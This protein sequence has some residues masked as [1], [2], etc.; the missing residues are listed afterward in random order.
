M[1]LLRIFVIESSRPVLRRP[2]AINTSAP[3]VRNA[4]GDAIKDLQGAHISL[5]A[6]PGDVQRQPAHGTSIPIHGGPGDPNGEFNAIYATFDPG[7]GFEPIQ[8]GSSYVQAVTW[9]DS[10]CPDARTI[11]TY[12]LS[13]NPRSPFFDDQTAMF[14][15]KQWVHERFCAADVKQH[16]VSITHV[17]SGAR[18][19]AQVTGHR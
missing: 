2:W 10:P 14:S 11:L 5:D 13:T 16:T 18:T 8:E 7:K 9:H 1:T 12:S 3:T 6:A 4:L 19:R 17:A 15:R